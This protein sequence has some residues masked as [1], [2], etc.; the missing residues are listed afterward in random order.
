M[1]LAVVPYYTTPHPEMMNNTA[2]NSNHF[3]LSGDFSWASIAYKLRSFISPSNG[4]TYTAKLN[5]LR[6]K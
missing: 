2:Q 6:N 3:E 5:W 4:S 1:T